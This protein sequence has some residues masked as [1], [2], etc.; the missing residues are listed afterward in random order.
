M[1][2]YAFVYL[3]LATQGALELLG[4]GDGAVLDY[5]CAD[6]DHQVALEMQAGGFQIQDDQP[7]LAQRHG[8]GRRRP[9]QL[10]NALLLLQG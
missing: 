7:L 9:L 2:Q 5:H 3:D 6:G 1:D 4:I 10:G 8:F